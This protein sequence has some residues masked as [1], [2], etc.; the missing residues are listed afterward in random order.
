[1]NLRRLALVAGGL[2][3]LA[4]FLATLR[5]L[6][7][8]SSAGWNWLADLLLVGIALLLGGLIGAGLHARHAAARKPARKAE[9]RHWQ[10]GPN[11]HWQQ[12]PS[13]PMLWVLP[14]RQAG[15]PV[16]VEEDDEPFAP[17]GF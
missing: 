1:M 13:A 15:H 11:A 10:S 5:R 14:E 4:A 9:K 12:A 8:A 3:L 6:L 16:E 7:P 17:W 2:L